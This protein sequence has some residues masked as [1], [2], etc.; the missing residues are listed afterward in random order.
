MGQPFAA[1]LKTL[2]KSRLRYNATRLDAALAAAHF[3]YRF[4]HDWQE[5]DRHE[6]A[7]LIAAY[8]AEKGM[9]AYQMHEA[10]KGK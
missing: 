9:D 1:I 8:R 5:L 4:F 2:P 6:Q 10:A 3:G 7:Y